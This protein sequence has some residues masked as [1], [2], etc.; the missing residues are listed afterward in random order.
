[1]QYQHFSFPSKEKLHAQRTKANA[2]A[3]SQ[4][5]LETRYLTVEEEVELVDHYVARL[6]DLC[7]H[8]RAP[9]YVRVPSLL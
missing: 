1:M 4:L 5:P 7:R 6:W 9:S 2:N 8:F 3:Q